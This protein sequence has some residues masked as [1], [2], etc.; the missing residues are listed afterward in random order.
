[1]KIREFSRRRLLKG[2]L[3]LPVAGLMPAVNGCG[4]KAHSTATQDATAKLGPLSV[5]SPPSFDTINIII[6]GFGI[7]KV[8]PNRSADGVTLMLPDIKLGHVHTVGSNN[9]PLDRSLVKIDIDDEYHFENLVGASAGTFPSFDTT[10][11]IVIPFGSVDTSSFDGPNGRRR[12]RL[13]YPKSIFSLKCGQRADQSPLINGSDSSIV[14]INPTTIALVHVLTYG[15]NAGGDVTLRRSDGT[16]VFEV[17][18][19]TRSPGRTNGN[20]HVHNSFPQPLDPAP[21]I[22]HANAAFKLYGKLKKTGDGPLK[23]GFNVDVNHM[24]IFK[25]I[26]N[27][28]FCKDKLPAGSGVDTS[29]DLHDP[30]DQDL[31]GPGANCLRLLVI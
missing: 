28:D 3:A 6:H 2:L 21:A 14:K 11:N 15:R 22:A 8:E 25:D 27:P 26:H 7:I 24:L 16:P 1:M 31:G 10:R 12:I 29:V 23:I 19:D 17:M 13:P 4:H 20:C 9:D 5:P 18:L 30:S